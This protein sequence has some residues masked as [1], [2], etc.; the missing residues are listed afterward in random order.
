MRNVKPK[1]GPQSDADHKERTESRKCLF[2]THPVLSR[3]G[4]GRLISNALYAKHCTDHINQLLTR[5]LTVIIGGSGDTKPK[6]EALVRMKEILFFYAPESHVTK[7]HQSATG[8]RAFIFEL[9]RYYKY[10][11]DIPTLVPTKV[12]RRG[13]AHAF[14]RRRAEFK[15]VSAAIREE[16]LREKRDSQLAQME[17]YNDKDREIRE[18]PSTQIQGTRILRLLKTEPDAE[19]MSSIAWVEPRSP[20]PM[21]DFFLQPMRRPASRQLTLPSER[22]RMSGSQSMK[23]RVT[24]TS[25]I[26]SKVPPP[27]IP[28]LS[29]MLELSPKHAELKKIYATTRKLR[30]KVTASVQSLATSM[31][32][33]GLLDSTEHTRR[34]LLLVSGHEWRPKIAP[35]VEKSP[36]GRQPQ[37]KSYDTMKKLFARMKVEPRPQ[38]RLPPAQPAM[39]RWNQVSGQAALPPASRMAA[40]RPPA[41]GVQFLRSTS[42]N[43]I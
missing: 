1:R 27:S 23:S 2:C 35:S 39:A 34:A 9:S 11:K 12:G 24:M 5:E 3:L 21:E 38:V 7:Y 13:L 15:Q 43:F 31:S 30:S 8:S 14:A 29:P 32:K 19:E 33:R 42:H 17:L 28:K 18:I 4:M 25:L 36:F 6:S 41:Q 40:R 20:T 37:K 10:H 16:L 22:P 26:G